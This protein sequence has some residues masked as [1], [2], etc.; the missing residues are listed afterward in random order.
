MLLR[1]YRLKNRQKYYYEIYRNDV[2]WATVLTF[3]DVLDL[4]FNDYLFT[5][6][7]YEYSFRQLQ[8]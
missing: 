5:E 4:I 1:T 2:L 6:G 3:S 7:G 8:V